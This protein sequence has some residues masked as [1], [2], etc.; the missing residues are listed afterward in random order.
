MLPVLQLGPLAIQ[1]SGLILLFGIWVGLTL[2]GRRAANHGL[3]SDSLDNL[4]IAALVG[5]AL[6]GRLTFAAMNLATFRASPLDLF[7][8]N[9]DLFDLTG[10]LAAGLLVALVYGQ[11]KGFSLWPTL[12][13]LTPFFGVMMVA[14]GL[15]HLASGAAFG[16][17]TS[18]PWGI[19]L[20]GAVRH[21]SQIYETTAAIFIL[22]L[23][24]MR[25]TSS[26]A[27][28]QFLAFAA[29]SAG[30]HLFLEAF[31]GDS[32]IVFGGLR[33]GQILAWIALAAA[34]FGLERLRDPGR[35]G[36]P[37]RENR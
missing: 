14:L 36:D 4:I 27:G 1:T 6:G 13:A 29:W 8:L 5:F 15:S 16:M 26:V 7:S 30:A 28:M 3:K 18:M 25:K 35:V 20:N 32:T 11:R 24:G 31:R 2:A 19:E 10:G 33:L 34:L 21:P 37:T 12:D 23:V 22:G 17:E 9:L